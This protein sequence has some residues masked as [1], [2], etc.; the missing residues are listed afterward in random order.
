M[1]DTHIVVYFPFWCA[2]HWIGLSYVRIDRFS[3]ELVPTPG[4]GWRLRLLEI[5]WLVME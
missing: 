5:S 3:L 4:D 2:S 1:G